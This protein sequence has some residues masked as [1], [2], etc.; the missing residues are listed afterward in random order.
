LIDFRF[1]PPDP[2]DKL[3]AIISTKDNITTVPSIQ[4]PSS[5]QYLI[6]PIATCLAENSAMKIFVKISL[7]VSITACLYGT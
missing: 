7:I 3:V 4:C 2:D 5:V 6:G 1:A